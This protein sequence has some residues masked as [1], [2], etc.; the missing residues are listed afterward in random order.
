MTQPVDVSQVIANPPESEGAAAPADAASR[1]FV[2][3][4]GATVFFVMLPVTLLVPALKELVAARYGASPFWTHF[5]LSC[6]LLGAALMAPFIG[7]LC[8]RP[9]SRVRTVAAALVADAAL[10]AGMGGAG[11]LALLLFLRFFEGAAHMLALSALMALAADRSEPRTRGRIM[12]AVGACM[13]FGTAAGTRIG[14]LISPAW[15]FGAAAGLAV[16]AA[17]FSLLF[18]TDSGR[19]G[20]R[21][22]LRGAATVVARR[23]ELL[24]AYAYTAMERFCVGVIIA[25]FVLFLADVHGLSPDARSRLLVTFLFPF[26][27]LVYPAGRCVDRLG[28]TLPLTLG[29]SC[30]GLTMAFYGYAPAGWLPAL[31]L[32]SGLLSSLMFAPTLSL[33]ADLAPPDQRGAVFAGFNAAG[34]LGFMAG[35]I[36][37]GLICEWFGAHDAAAGYRAAFAVAGLSLLLLSL[38]V[39]PWL[40]RMHQRGMIR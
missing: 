15:I 24:A 16:L 25:S 5:F 21:H 36:T 2:L 30:F 27:L 6:N 8:D 31:M 33:C 17:C 40:R 13:M 28:T 14:G 29:A 35:P 34:S 11:S 12:G 4:A 10:L 26:A 32:L 22:G 1:G 7:A 23:P 37:G 39:L 18:L 19:R 3:R 38:A 20:P 9:G